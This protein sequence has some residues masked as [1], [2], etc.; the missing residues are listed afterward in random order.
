MLPTGDDFM[1]RRDG[2]FE[3]KATWGE[4][5][6]GTILADTQ[7]RT[8]RWEIVDVAMGTPVPFGKTLWMRA[9]EVVTLEERTIQPRAKVS[10]VI[11]LTRSP[12]DTSLGPLAPPSDAE[13]IMLVVE[14]LGATELASID[15]ATGE[16]VCPDYI[17]ESHRPD[18]ESILPGLLEHMR[19]AHNMDPRPNSDLVTAIQAHG[20]AHDEN[21]PIGKTGFPHTHHLEIKA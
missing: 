5:T 6:V 8:K 11:V 17:Y 13:A 14:R 3:H 15:T 19:I 12:A 16:V 21:D 9:R 7:T 20:R 2:W 18:D 4:V 1:P 10:K